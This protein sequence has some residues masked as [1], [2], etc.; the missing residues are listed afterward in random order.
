MGKL[1][2]N[3]D[4]LLL[5]SDNPRIG[6]AE[7][8]RDALQKVLDDQGKKLAELAEDIATEGMS[9]IDR[10][11]VIR[12][13]KYGERF[14]VVEGNRRLAA[15]KILANPNVLGSLHLAAPLQKRFER[16]AKNDFDRATV[17]PLDCFLVASRTEAN[18]WIWLRHTGEN[19]GRGVV[20]WSGVAAAHFR[21]TDPALQ[22][23]EFVRVHGN[24]TAD[25]MDSLNNFPITTL[26]RLLSTTEVRQLVGIEVKEGHLR[27]GLPGEEL[28]K[29]LRRMVLDLAEKKV[30]VSDLKD[31]KAQ[32]AYIRLFDAADKPKL[33]KVGAVRDVKDFTSGE[34]KKPAPASGGSKKKGYNP[35][36][37]KTL[38]PSPLKLNITEEKIAD[39]YRELRKLRMEDY[40]NSCAV[41]L[42]VFLELSLDA[43]MDKNGIE[44]QFKDPQ[45]GRARDKTLKK[46]VTDVVDDLVTKKGFKRSEFTAVARAVGDSTSPLHIDLLHA[47]VHSRF[48]T[49]TAGNL[50]SAWTAAEPLFG[51]VWA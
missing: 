32:A 11:L 9:P 30:T 22:A 4:Q 26:D 23:L 6:S 18:R 17:E 24:L 29:P 27:S 13:K 51:R 49:P 48:E 38:I 15:L 45:S 34:F 39:I 2:L 1:E 10:L 41:L 35:A 33:S 20:N 14:I 19:G 40:P 43:Y 12:D 36:Q 7:N 47:Y 46:K 50:R 8:S 5:D 28:I 31:R 44:N 42:R 21:G 25:Q 16:I 37:R 3:I